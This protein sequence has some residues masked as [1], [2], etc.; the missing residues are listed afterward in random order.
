MRA[1]DMAQPDGTNKGKGGNE[2]MLK[3]IRDSD[4][5]NKVCEPYLIDSQFMNTV[6]D[7]IK[8]KRI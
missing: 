4:M 2:C 8:G 5:G 3:N 6:V 1:E 7:T